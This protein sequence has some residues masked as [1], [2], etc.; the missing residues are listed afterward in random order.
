METHLAPWKFDK[1]KNLTI[2]T[3]T[4]G[5][6]VVPC[7]LQDPSTIPGS[8]RAEIWRE[9]LIS[10]AKEAVLQKYEKTSEKKFSQIFFF[11]PD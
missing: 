9:K 5:A 10:G 6:R 8:P 4:E 2:H 7:D 3:H 1:A 11:F